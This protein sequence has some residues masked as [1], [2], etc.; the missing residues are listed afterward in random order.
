MKICIAVAEKSED[1][2]LELLYLGA[3]AEAAKKAVEK[4][5]ADSKGYCAAAAFRKPAPFKQ[6]RFECEVANERRNKAHAAD[7][8]R[9]RKEHEAAVAAL[10]AEKQ[11]SAKSAKKTKTI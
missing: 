4:I 7:Q 5:A 8:D 9:Q 1:G 11:K 6:F 10:E 2:K 3:D